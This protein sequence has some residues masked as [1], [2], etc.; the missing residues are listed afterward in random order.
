[1]VKCCGARYY[2][3]HVEELYFRSMLDLSDAFICVIC[4]GVMV[5]DSGETTIRALVLTNLSSYHTFR[6][7]GKRKD[8]K[9]AIQF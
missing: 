3:K 4:R 9:K 8:A 5:D 7:H 2:L 6:E 1:M